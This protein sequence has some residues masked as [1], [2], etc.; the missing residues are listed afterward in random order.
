ML[1]LDTIQS[2]LHTS[3]VGKSAI[4][5]TYL[6]P[7]ISLA[8]VFTCLAALSNLGLAILVFK[9]TRRKNENDVRIKW[10]QELVY[11]PNKDSLISF[12]KNLYKIEGDVPKDRDLTNDE[13]IRI[14]Q[15]IKKERAD[16]MLSFVD[17][18]KPIAPVMYQNIL[19]SVDGLADELTKVFD[20]DELR[21]SNAKTYDRE[22]TNK[23]KTFRNAIIIELFNYKGL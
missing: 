9:Y 11:T 8:P 3:S 18:I 7:F 10:F 23:I 4:T 19:R 17:L 1:W 20:N 16:L 21:L 2:T 6:T 12:F 22:V 13:K 5:S 14:M 15:V